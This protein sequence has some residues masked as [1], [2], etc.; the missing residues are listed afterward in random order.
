MRLKHYATM[1][2]QRRLATY[3]CRKAHRFEL[4]EGR[5]D[6]GNRGFRDGM[7]CCLRSHLTV[8]VDFQLDPEDS[9]RYLN[10]AGRAWD[11]ELEG[12][13]ATEPSMLISRTTGWKYEGFESPAKQLVDDA[14]AMIRVEQDAAGLD[15]PATVGEEAQRLLDE[16]AGIMPE[17]QF[18]LDLLHEWDS[19]VYMLMHLARGAFGVPMAEALFCRSAGRSGKDTSANLMCSLLGSYSYSISC[20]ALCSIPSPDSPSPTFAQLRARRFIAIREVGEQKLAGSLF[21]RFVDPISELSGR[22]LYDSP[23]RFRP[24]YLA[25]FCSNKPMQVD[26]MD[27]AVKARTAVID[28]G[29]I[30]TTTPSEATH[31]KWKDIASVLPSYRPGLFWLL[32]RV[33]RYLLKDRPMRTVLP[34]PESSSEARELDCRDSAES[35]WESFL[36]RSLQPARGPTEA[37]AAGEV[38]AAVVRQMGI[39]RAGAQLFLQ[40]RGFQRVRR[41]VKSRNV[42]VYKYCF[43]V[44][45]AKALA[46]LYVKLGGE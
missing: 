2:L 30:F 26:H 21:K 11:R 9:R 29:S 14:L 8:A 18:W 17:L 3:H 46:P 6:I 31:R 16:A 35:A 19:I 33:F 13:V 7:E 27:A 20:D 15:S 44:N 41:V 32:T 39:E 5:H 23:V 38:D 40:A 43:V 4:E 10:F 42:Y 28:Y 25:F 1:M 45:G 37:S 22:N 12:F 36:A 24:Q 34:V